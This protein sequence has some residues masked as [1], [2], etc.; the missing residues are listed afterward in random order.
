MFTT[1][2]TQNFTTLVALVIAF[3]PL[4]VTVLK[5]TGTKAGKIKAPF[6]SSIKVIKIK[7]VPVDEQTYIHSLLKI[8]FL[9]GLPRPHR[10]K[11]K[12]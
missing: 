2:I 10:L 3:V 11:L 1:F 5:L 4:L 12:I 9:Q 8:L 7:R 6:D